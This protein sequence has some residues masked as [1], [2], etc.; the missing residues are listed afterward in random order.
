MDFFSIYFNLIPV[1]LVQGLA[2]AF[3]AMGIM[4]PFR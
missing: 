2:Y 4:I 1:T 3:V